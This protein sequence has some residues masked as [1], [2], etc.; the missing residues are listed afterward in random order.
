MIAYRMSRI[1]LSTTYQQFILEVRG[2]VIVKTALLHR[3]HLPRDV[4]NAESGETTTTRFA[5]THAVTKET[6]ARDTTRFPS[7]RRLDIHVDSMCK[8]KVL[9]LDWLIT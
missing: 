2:S 1:V 4:L 3:D 9:H 5:H 8:V 6:H 7:F